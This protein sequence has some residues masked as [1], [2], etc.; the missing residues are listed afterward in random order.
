MFHI[1]P[2]IY[3]RIERGKVSDGGMGGKERGRYLEEVHEEEG[4]LCPIETHLFPLSHSN[5]KPLQHTYSA[6]VKQWSHA[7]RQ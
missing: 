2:K 4:L 7:F 3:R 5:K 1:T 6:L